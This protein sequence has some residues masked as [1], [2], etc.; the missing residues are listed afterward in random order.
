MTVH[1]SE[2]GSQ[3]S[4]VVGG[5]PP[6]LHYRYGRVTQLSAFESRT[7]VVAVTVRDASGADSILLL[8]IDTSS[9]AAGSGVRGDLPPL[10]PH[11]ALAR[12]LQWGGVSTGLTGIPETLGRRKSSATAGTSTTTADGEEE[13]MDLAFDSELQKLLSGLEGEEVDEEENWAEQE[14]E[15]EQEQ[16]SEEEHMIEGNVSVSS[17][18][19]AASA[20]QQ[21][22][23][24]MSIISASRQPAIQPASADAV[25]AQGGSNAVYSDSGRSS[26]GAVPDTVEIIDDDEEVYLRRLDQGVRVRIVGDSSQDSPTHK[27]GAMQ[28]QSDESDLSTVELA[29]YEDPLVP[30]ESTPDATLIAT[31]IKVSIISLS[32]F[33]L[34]DLFYHIHFT[35][36]L[37][38]VF[39]ITIDIN[40]SMFFLLCRSDAR[41]IFGI[42]VYEAC[43]CS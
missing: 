28:R 33:Q 36:T 10:A 20:A 14:H 19:K 24:S 23:S 38:I 12:S 40:C 30:I 41:V 6:A 9:D 15:H 35:F 13:A 29:P 7:N 18:K 39:L 27:D 1:P 26:R 21:S 2:L 17:K 34:L 3:R 31:F 8:R 4:S 25:H 37:F 16:E 5:A 22:H 11:P 43:T 32:F 42:S